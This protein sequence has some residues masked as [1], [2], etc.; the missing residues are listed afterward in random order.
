MGK[1]EFVKPELTVEE[2]SLA[3]FQVNQKLDQTNKALV[4]A[5]KEQEEIFANISHDL[6]SPVTAIRNSVEYL[7]SLETL[8]SED[9][10]PLLSL[11]DR[12][13]AYLEQLIEEVFLLVMVDSM[14]QPLQREEINIGMFLEDF[15]FQCEA[16]LKY[17]KRKLTLQVPEAFPYFVS[18]D[19]KMMFRVLDNLFSNAL[20]YSRENASISLSATLSDKNHILISVSD[21]GVGIAKEHLNQIFNRTYMVSG[22][23]TPGQYTGCGLGLAI[24]KSIVENHGGTIFCESEVGKGSTFS[25]TLP[26]RRSKTI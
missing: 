9:A 14:K 12:R 6:R 17:A 1:T 23:R 22:S 2:L 25:F 15:F 13:V 10:F 16:D 8:D 19:C 26:A 21:T 11:I 24:A 3:L 20:K 7:L 18:I 5:K 4:K